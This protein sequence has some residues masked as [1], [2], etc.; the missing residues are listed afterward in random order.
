MCTVNS[1]DDPYKKDSKDEVKGVTVKCT[2]GDQLTDAVYECTKKKKKCEAE[3]TFILLLKRFFSRTLV[4][5]CLKYYFQYT[6]KQL[7]N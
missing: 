7:K 3:V 1:A 4:F 2:V 6:S 5:L